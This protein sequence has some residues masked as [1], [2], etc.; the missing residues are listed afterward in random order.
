MIDYRGK[1]VLIVGGT[2]PIGL[3]TA[4]AFGGRG[5]CCVL[6]DPEDGPTADEVREQFRAAGALPPLLVPTGGTPSDGGAALFRKLKRHDLSP[7]AFVSVLPD[8]GLVHDLAQWSERAAVQSIRSVGWPTCE[9]LLRLRE[10]CGRY[11]R[12][13]VAVSPDNPDDYSSGFDLRRSSAAMLEVL[14]RSLTYRLRGEDVRTNVLRV[15]TAAGR[16]FAA[17][18]GRLGFGDT[19]VEPD[20]VAGTVLALCS[21]LLDGVRGQVITVDRGGTFIDDLSWLYQHRARLGL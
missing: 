2:C 14:C 18:A 20:E 9:Y 15:R 8:G 21:G 19:F 5:A 13:V 4:L 16:E 1:C 6:G 12:Y 7:E 3:A 10:A 11:P 17:F